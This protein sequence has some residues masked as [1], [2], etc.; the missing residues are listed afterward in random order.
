[1]QDII[2][3]TNRLFLRQMRHT[4][5]PALAGVLCDSESMRYYKRPFD[6]ERVHAWIDWCLESYKNNGYGLWAVV[7]KSDLKCIGD[8]GI[9][10]QVV[11]GESVDEIGYHILPSLCCKGYATEAALAVLNYSFSKIGLNRVVSY[12]HESNMAS[13]RVAE[14]MGMQMIKSFVKNDLPQ[15]LYAINEDMKEVRAVDSVPRRH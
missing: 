2:I 9:T 10:K 15:V 11:D 13:R 5:A 12:M 3:E 1:M 7:M 4:D 6:M 14:K 8:C